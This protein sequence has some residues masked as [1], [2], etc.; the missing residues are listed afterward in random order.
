ML[1]NRLTQ[2]KARHL[3]Y[4]ALHCTQASFTAPDGN[5]MYSS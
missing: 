4:D 2:K 1:A 5:T 3:Y